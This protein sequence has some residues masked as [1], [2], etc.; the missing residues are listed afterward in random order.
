MTLA[1]VLVIAAVLA[2]AAIVQISVAQ[3]LQ[4]SRTAN[5]AAQIQVIDVEAFRNL[6]N[7]ADDEYLRCRLPAAQFR[8]VRRARLRA[9][10]AYIQMAGRNAAVL[11][12]MG[13]AALASGDPRTMQASRELVNEA[14]LLR[15]NTALAL[16]RIYIA[17]AW[18]SYG[19]A[20]GRVADHYDRLSR[21]AM[22][23]GRLQNPALPF[24]ISVTHSV[25]R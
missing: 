1:I 15:R 4:V 5:L 22:L 17:L 21:S 7:P 16:V 6:A 25:L 8:L 19:L 10:A 24:R 13:E 2:L 9:M 3:R 18:P 11:V 12:R 20:A 23:L 14:L